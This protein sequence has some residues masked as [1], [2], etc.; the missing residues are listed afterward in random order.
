M[1]KKKS[2]KTNNKDSQFYFFFKCV[3]STKIYGSFTPFLHIILKLF[4][5]QI[6]IS[7][8][9]RYF[10][11][12]TL[13]NLQIA[14]PLRYIN[15]PRGGRCDK[16]PRYFSRIPQTPCKIPANET[17]MIYEENTLPTTVTNLWWPGFRREFSNRGL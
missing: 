7:H 12:W 1:M 2:V 9:M 11:S 13:L 16:Y 3:K 4:I 6:V 8:R 17:K 14:S 10:K 5:W 15:K